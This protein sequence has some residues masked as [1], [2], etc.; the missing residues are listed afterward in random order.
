M[1]THSG[2][3]AWRIPWTEEPGSHSPWDHKES[4]MTDFT[5]TFSLL[6]VNI[7]S[8][9]VGVTSSLVPLKVG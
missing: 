9:I 6:Y 1:A 4:D 5:F 7:P 2:T 8:Y 3:L